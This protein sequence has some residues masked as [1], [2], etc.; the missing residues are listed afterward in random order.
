M[1]AAR[2]RRRDSVDDRATAAAGRRW[3]PGNVAVAGGRW[4]RPG[5]GGDRPTLTATATT[6][7]VRRAMN[8]FL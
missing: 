6:I 5:D 2:Q 3:R 4:W 8:E 1:M 7:A